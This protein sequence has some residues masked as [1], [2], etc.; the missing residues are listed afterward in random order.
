GPGWVWIELLV[1]CMWPP[2]SWCDGPSLRASHPIPVITRTAPTAQVRRM[3]SRFAARVRAAFPGLRGEGGFTLIES[4]MAATL[5]VMVGTTL[6]GVLASS[7]VTY[8]SSRERTI[9][10]QLVQDQVEAIRRMPFSSVGLPNGNP[11]G[12]LL[13]SRAIDTVGLHG[14][15]KL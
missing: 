14:T 2:W 11:A 5:L 10:E 13:A 12:T 7:V 1:I 4:M 3:G 9:A 15:I 6:S 8:S